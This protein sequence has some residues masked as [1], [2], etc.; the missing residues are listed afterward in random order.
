MNDT[1]TMTTPQAPTLAAIPSDELP[2]LARLIHKTYDG[3]YDIAQLSEV[4]A[5]ALPN[6]TDDDRARAILCGLSALCGELLGRIQLADER[7]GGVLM[8]GGTLAQGR[9]TP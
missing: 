7:L 4:A 8:Q 6:S 9:A 2:N 1:T 5:E 3:L